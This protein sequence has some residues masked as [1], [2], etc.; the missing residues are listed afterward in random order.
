[1]S[2]DFATLGRLLAEPAPEQTQAEAP[3]PGPMR[4]EDQ[5]DIFAP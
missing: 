3:A 2:E 1:M 4:G 5:L